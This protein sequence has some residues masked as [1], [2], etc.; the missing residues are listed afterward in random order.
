MASACLVAILLTPLAFAK[1]IVVAFSPYKPPYVIDKEVR[2]LEIDIVSEALA[3]EGVTLKV[4]FFDRRYLRQAMKFGR[5]DAAAGLQVEDDKLYYS[6]VYISFQNTIISRSDDDIKLKAIADLKGFQFASWRGAHQV[7]GKEFN[8]ASENGASPNYIE[9]DNQL[10]QNKMF[11]A[12][13]VDLLVIDPFVFKWYQKQLSESFVTSGQVTFHPLLPDK[14]NYHL[15]FNTKELQQTFNLG[16]KKLKKSGRYDELTAEYLDA[17]RVPPIY[18]HY[19]EHSPYLRTSHNGIYGL[20]ATPAAKAFKTA[21]LSFKWI[22]TPANKQFNVLKANDS[23]DCFIGRYRNLA[24]EKYARLTYPVYTDKPRVALFRKDNP[25]KADTL[26]K[27]FS[28]SKKVMLVKEAYSY[29]QYV[30]QM[31]KMNKPRRLMLAINTAE[32]LVALSRRKADYMLIMPEEIEKTF[33]AA[34]LNIDDFNTQLLSDIPSGEQH[35]ILCS[36]QVGGET[37]Q[38]LNQAIAQQSM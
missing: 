36:M 38:K 13:R 29:G 35:N 20:T 22:R 18:L 5:T 19:N 9:Y 34:G 2:G 10:I 12:H 3:L 16:L 25:I 6:D 7:L 21:G 23:K 24:Q 30:D 1:E 17:E 28:D 26:D 15:G 31:V 27:L 11:W 8:E 14:T 33:E 37:I 32:M 4:D